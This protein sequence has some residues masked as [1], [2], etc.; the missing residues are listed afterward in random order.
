MSD[1][2]PVV[3]WTDLVRIVKQGKIREL[4]ACEITFNGEY[5][6]TALIPHG[7]MYSGDYIRTQ[8]EYLALKANIT[9]GLSPEELLS[10]ETADVPAL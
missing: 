2:I 3:A 1:L 4:K 7:D 8:G 9:G 6:F 5:L 10:K